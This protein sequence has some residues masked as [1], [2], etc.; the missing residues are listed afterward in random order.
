MVSNLDNF[1]SSQ[2]VAVGGPDFEYDNSFF[3]NFSQEIP[4]EGTFGPK[5][6]HFHVFTKFCN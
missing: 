5:F 1:A 2:N 4:K 3:L 6:T